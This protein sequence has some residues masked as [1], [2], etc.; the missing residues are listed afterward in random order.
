MSSCLYI[1][2]R[3]GFVNAMWSA[4]PYGMRIP[5]L[6]VALV[7]AISTPLALSAQ[8]NPRARPIEVHEASIRDLQAAM[9]EGRTT[10]VAIVDAYLARIAAFDRGGPRI[11]AVIRLNPRA[12]A[13]AAALDRERAAGRV[14]GIWHGIPII[15]KDNFE[16]DDLPATG[17]SAA[18]ASIAATGDGFVVR[19]LREAGAI[20]LGIANMQELAFGFENAS[21]LG[22]QTLNPYDLNRCPGGSSGGTAAAIA[23]SFAAIGWGT[24]TC[25]SIRVPAAF[26]NL[27]GLRPTQGI[28]SRAGVLPLTL[29]GDNVGPMARTIADL[30]IGLDITVGADS[31]DTTTN[32]LRGR[33]L[34]RFVDSLGVV[35]L[36]GAR[37]GVFQPYFRDAHPDVVS[38]VRAAIRAMQERGAE[39]VEVSA[40]LDTFAGNTSLVFAEMRVAMDG[41]LA[42]LPASPVRTLQDLVGTGLH[43]Q[44]ADDRIRPASAI[45]SDDAAVRSRN[46]NARRAALRAAI[47]AVM[48]SLRLDA[49]VYP[50]TK[51]PA[52]MI[53]EIPQGISCALAAHSGFPALAMPAGFTPT[54]VPIGLELL[55][56]PFSDARLLS[57]GYA[58]E[59][60]G[61][62]R[63][64]PATT[65][66]LSTA[67]AIASITTTVRAGGASARAILTFD[68]GRSYVSWDVNVK[69][70]PE[71]DLLGIYLQRTDSAGNSL[72]VQRLVAPG[73]SRGAGRAELRAAD[74]DALARGAMMVRLVT[75]RLPGGGSAVVGQ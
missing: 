13:Q 5:A 44:T 19:R 22:G 33:P 28:V 18:L 56:R 41:W 10:A 11:N 66:A 1:G 52:A 63:Q 23:A 21:S 68:R 29:N 39:V 57:L 70:A 25:G 53:G 26:T 43:H 64:S 71:S 59:Q 65:P 60:S 35:S 12:R 72:V 49:L 50:S 54:G 8:V 15:L 2:T 9:T 67:P 69:G 6:R 4:L 27:V 47:L 46:V 3:I 7:A 16:T 38:T 36:R 30:A 48:D 20:V 74:R 24:D 40:P 37:I 31:A 45:T 17:G 61:S 34:P 32:V 42:R 58:F 14:R 51:Q 55:G 62:R 73:S 75:R